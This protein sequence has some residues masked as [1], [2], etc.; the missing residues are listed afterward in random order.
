MPLKW[1]IL[2]IFLTVQAIVLAVVFARMCIQM[3]RGE[4]I[5]IGF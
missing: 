5:L 4:I 1:K 3:H 2:L